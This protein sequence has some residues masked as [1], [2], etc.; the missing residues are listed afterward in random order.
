MIANVRPSGTTS[1]DNFNGRMVC[2]SG[3][4]YPGATLLNVET[5]ALLFDIEIGGAK[6][7]AVTLDPRTGA[8]CLTTQIAASEKGLILARDFTP[9]RAFNLRRGRSDWM[10]AQCNDARFNS[11]V[12]NH[13]EFSGGVCNEPGIFD[14]S[15]FNATGDDSSSGR[16]KALARGLTRFAPLADAPPISLSATWQSHQP[17][18]FVVNLPADL[19]PQFGARFNDAH[20]GSKNPDSETFKGLVLDPPNDAQHV[21]T[22]LSKDGNASAL[23]YAQAV[24]AVPI[25]WEGESVPF[26]QPRR[27]QLTGGNAQRAAALYLQEQGVPGAVAIF[28]RSPGLQGNDISISVRYANPGVFDIDVHFAPARFECARAIAYAGRVLPSDEDLIPTGAPVPIGVIQ[29][30]AAGIHAAVTRE[31]T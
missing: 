11:A 12:F 15:R 5:L 24:P 17:G 16:P 21:A 22:V 31:R 9:S 6:Y 27:R 13:A 14:F 26:G 4:W 28:A 25:G 23:V 29:A 20:F 19:P 10:L 18:A 1:F 7:S 3:T 30:K 8:R 2:A